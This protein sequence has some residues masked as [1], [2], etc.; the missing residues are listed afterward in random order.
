MMNYT[1]GYSDMATLTHE[2]GHALHTYFAYRTQPF[3]TAGSSSFVGEVA[4]H[5]N[6]VLLKE[7]ML[8]KIQE[9][10]LLLYFLLT[11]IESSIFDQARV[12]EFELRIHQEVENGN[13]LTGDT[14]SGIYLETLRKYYGHHQGVCIVPDFFDMA[15]S[16]DRLLIIRTYRIYLYATSQI[17]AAALAEKVLTGEKGAVEKYL[18]LLSA[19]GSDYPINIL[20]KAGVDM[21]SPE[22]FQ[23]TMDSMVRTMDKIERILEK[24]GI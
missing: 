2:L 22:P 7:K 19:G 4:S 6:E 9:D 18:D 16:I 13:T 8:E 10:D 1:G 15:W 12:S 5:F 20:K 24:K 23:K 3:P 17:A 14:I 11:N 21:A